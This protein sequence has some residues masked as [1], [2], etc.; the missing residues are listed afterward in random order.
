MEPT[1]ELGQLLELIHGARYRFETV[2]A[3]IRRWHHPQR[4]AEAFARHIEESEGTLFVGLEGTPTDSRP[5]TEQAV[6][7]LWVDKP[8]RRVR[9]EWQGRSGG[10]ELGI[11]VGKRWWMYDRYTGAIS[12]EDDLSHGS[13]VG[14]EFQH[15]FDPAPLLS[16]LDLEPLGEERVAARAGVRA[17]AIPRRWDEEQDPTDL[18]LHQ[19]GIG[20]DE[21][22]LVVDR[23]RGV[24]LRSEA[25][26]G[27]ASYDIS[28]VIEIAFDEDFPDETFVFEPP[29][30]ESVR[31]VGI[32][33]VASVTIEEAAAQ[34]PFRIFI[35]ARLP[36]RWEMEVH[37]MKGE[38]RPPI[39][40]G[41]SI[42]YHTPDATHQFT[43]QEGP[44]ADPDPLPNWTWSEQIREGER[45]QFWAPDD[46]HSRL[47]TR[48]R[49]ERQGTTIT[50]MSSDLEL[51]ALVQ[52]ADSLVPAPTEP[53]LLGA[54]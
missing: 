41:V 14:Q 11:R 29:A 32:H 24:L 36:G 25:R 20:A 40:P 16:A 49:V 5:E 23:E 28:E 26:L 53:P 34:A 6:C 15:F 46:R 1:S 17:R 10:F 8:G 18:F 37:F 43:L 12:N 13:G 45:I 30:G 3:T 7:E 54:G 52:L 22:E 33:A 38:E 50:I 9:E 48:V 39:P 35:P 2:R 51:E 42:H 19:L 31:P 47:P 27:N 4:S 44:L 21:W